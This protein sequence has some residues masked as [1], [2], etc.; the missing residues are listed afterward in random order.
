MRICCSLFKWKYLKNQKLFINFLFHLWNLH[1]ILNIFEKK[2]IVIADEFPKLLPA[3]NSVKALSTKRRF[4]TSIRSQCVNG[5]QTVLKSAL[6]HLYHI[7]WSLWGEMICKISPWLK[8][9]ILEVFVNTLTADDKYPFWD[10]E[11]LKFPI[12]IQLSQKQKNFSE[13]FVPF[14]ESSS[15]SKHFQKKDDRDC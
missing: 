7:F 3:K 11:N 1:E 13:F 10:C 4:R 9:E 8:L 14:M 15:N 12:Q 5:C 6:E 2:G